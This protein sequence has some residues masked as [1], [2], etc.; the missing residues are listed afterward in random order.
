MISATRRTLRRSVLVSAAITGIALAPL[1]VSHFDDKEPL[2]SYR[3][4]YFTLLATNFGPMGAMVKG[5]MAW[6][7]AMMKT[8]A[9]D[10]AALAE[11]DLMRG[12]A[13]GSDKGTTRAKPGIWDNTDDFADKYANLQT[14]AREL[15]SVVSSGGDRKAIA[16]AVGATGKACKACHDDYKAKNYLY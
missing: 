3:Q 4:S 12:F 15:N 1:A 13:P 16:Q 8:Y 6:D 10:L 7:D 14:A 11:L 2:Q 5:D 9:H